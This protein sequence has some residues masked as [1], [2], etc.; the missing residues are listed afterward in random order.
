VV[1][2]IYGSMDVNCYEGGYIK[3]DNTT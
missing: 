3:D 2:A 1:S